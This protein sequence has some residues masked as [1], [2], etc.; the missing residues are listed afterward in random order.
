MALA[1]PV[2]VLADALQ[3]DF[4]IHLGCESGVI[5]RQL[6]GVAEQMLLIEVRL[7][8]EKQVVHFPKAS[9]RSGALGGLC[10]P[11]GMRMYRL[12]RKVSIGE[13][14]LILKALEKQFYRGRRLLAC[15]ALEV[16]VLH[17]R[18]RRVWVAQNVIRP[19]HRLSEIGSGVRSHIVSSSALL[20]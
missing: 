8:R 11:Q 2:E 4:V 7:I 17:H 1:A 3:V 12:L 18:D 10:G 14:D 5:E 19:V 20:L 9:L 13:E 16:A 6:L 15:W